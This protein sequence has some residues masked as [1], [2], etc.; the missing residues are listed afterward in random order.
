[1]SGARELTNKYGIVPNKALG[2]NFLVDSGAIERIVACAAK[3]GIP[4]L[5][6]GPGLGALTVPLSETGLP[7]TAV[8]LDEKMCAILEKEAPDVIIVHSDFLKA[9]LEKIHADLG[10]GALSVVGNLPYYVTSPI[11]SRLVCSGLPIGR[12]TLMM[13]KEAAARFTA[14]PG[15]KNY[16]P[17][18]LLTRRMYRVSA[19]MELSP[20]SYWPAPEVSS[21]VLVFEPTGNTMPEGLPR[22]VKCAFAMRR[23]TVVNN[24]AAMGVGKDRAACVLREAGI[25]PSARAES[26]TLDDFLNIEALLSR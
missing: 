3:P 14:L 5:E 17:L 11:V 20:A 16:V 6:I 8:E 9:N 19:L 22:L 23:K 26:L 10:G 18:T 12:M 7:V 24:L 2:Q 25:D 4:I 13:Q 21:S 1:M 15:S